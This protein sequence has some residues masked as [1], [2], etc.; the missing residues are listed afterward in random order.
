MK[1]Y[2]FYRSKRRILVP[3]INKRFLQMSYNFSF[4][5]SL[6]PDDCLLKIAN[7]SF[8][9][10]FCERTLDRYHGKIRRNQDI[11]IA[12]SR[13]LQIKKGE[14]FRSPYFCIGCLVKSNSY[15]IMPFSMANNSHS[16]FGSHPQALSFKE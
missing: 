12:K 15:K 3:E 6:G 14:D 13:I 16:C 7:L 8:G 4:Q 9:R 10:S 5:L 1:K 2:R 11:K